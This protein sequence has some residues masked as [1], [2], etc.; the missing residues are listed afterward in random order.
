VKGKN[1]MSGMIIDSPVQS[2]ACTVGDAATGLK[3]LVLC[4]PGS[5]ESKH[6]TILMDAQAG[7]LIV[8]AFTQ[9]KVSL[10]IDYA[11]ESL[12]SPRAPAAGWVERVW[13]D[14][15]RGLFGLVRWNR[16]TAEAIRRDEWR[17]LSPTLR[18]RLSDRRAVELHS[19]GLT[20][21][22]A[23]VGMLRIAAQEGTPTKGASMDGTE[24]FTGAE[25][26]AM[27]LVAQLAKAL[28]LEGT[29]SVV[30]VLKA[31]LAIVSKGKGASGDEEVAAS[32]RRILQLAPDAA[33]SQVV[34][35]LTDRLQSKDGTELVRMREEFADLSKRLE[36]SEFQQFIAPYTRDNKI[37]PHDELVMNAVH[38]EFRRDRTALKANLDKR[39]SFPEPGR[40]TPPDRKV[41]ER[42]RLIANAAREWRGSEQLKKTC[43]LRAFVSQSLSDASL[44]RLADDEAK[45]LTA[46]REAERF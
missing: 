9:H 6:G 4:P 5:V 31:A 29:E 15:G 11:H 39:A 12:D 26:E 21:K 36:E 30:E 24:I 27:T 37:N 22:P 16:D 34:L 3:T 19:L 17:Y 8:E 32:V 1:T 43:E 42:H 44:A 23:I 28:G 10:P 13:F 40:T 33:G 38:A 20:H 41:V 14:E 25:G 35:E 7:R 45:E 18:I 46:A 2:V